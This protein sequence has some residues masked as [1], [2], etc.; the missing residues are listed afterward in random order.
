MKQALSILMHMGSLHRL[1]PLWLLGVILMLV[2]PSWWAVLALA[3]GAVMQFFVEYVMHRFL[4]HREPPTDQGVFNDLYRSH[5]AHHEYPT[6][7]EYFTGGDNWFAVKFGL[8]SVALHTM[9]L[10]PFV[11]LDRKS[12]V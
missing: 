7:P 11:G 6:D 3:Y 10:W 4:Y 8:I 5:I 1:A 12:V 9:I 2:Y